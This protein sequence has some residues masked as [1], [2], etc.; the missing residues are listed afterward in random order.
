MQNNMDKPEEKHEKI[1][2]KVLFYWYIVLAVL[3]LGLIIAG[4]VLWIA[5]GELTLSLA[6]TLSGGVLILIY[7][8][9]EISKNKS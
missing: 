5:K 1:A 4:I 8:I 7:S 3:G 2:R 9:Y 6:P